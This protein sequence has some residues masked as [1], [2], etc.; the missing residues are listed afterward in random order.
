MPSNNYPFVQERA[1]SFVKTRDGKGYNTDDL[2]RDTTSE[3]GESDLD[4]FL[5]RAT[6]T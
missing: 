5:D 3:E 1:V 4:M 2:L 6:V